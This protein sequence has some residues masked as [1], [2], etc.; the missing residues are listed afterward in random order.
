[1]L[2]FHVVESNI[3][4]VWGNRCA[5]RM[6]PITHISPWN[7]QRCLWKLKVP[8]C[9]NLSI[10][11]TWEQRAWLRNRSESS[12]TT[13]AY[14]TFVRQLL[15]PISSSLTASSRRL[16]GQI[17]APA[18][19]AAA[20]PRPAEDRVET[21]GAAHRRLLSH[22]IPHRLSV[23]QH[24]LLAVLHAMSTR[25]RDAEAEERLL[26]PNAERG[27]VAS[28]TQPQPH[29]TSRSGHRTASPGL[30]SSVPIP[31]A[32]GVDRQ[33]FGDG[34]PV[35]ETRRIALAGDKHW[36][37]LSGTRLYFCAY[38][39]PRLIVRQRWMERSLAELNF[40]GGCSNGTGELSR[41]AENWSRGWR[42]SW[43]SSHL[44]RRG[45]RVEIVSG[46]DEVV[47]TRRENI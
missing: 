41:R 28:Q 3:L 23:L 34:V 5:R 40:A 19:P 8:T 4:R 1:M 32:A 44:K 10:L 2:H 26:S 33:W 30:P 14:V 20:L 43:R 7:H 37:A 24:R 18:A 42:I 25:G 45:S 38:V 15:L 29:D 16:S 31:R 47:L 35:G 36:R 22:H 21:T 6:N 27:D 13:T 12:F 17:E 9:I 39:I 11:V 46:R